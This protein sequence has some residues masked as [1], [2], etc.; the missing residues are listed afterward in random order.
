MIVFQPSADSS[1][2]VEDDVVVQTGQNQEEEEIEEEPEDQPTA[3]VDT[4]AGDP[5][6]IEDEATPESNIGK[7]NQSF[8]FL[9]SPKLFLFF[10]I[11]GNLTKCA[12]VQNMVYV[13]RLTKGSFRTHF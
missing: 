2:P 1:Q 6:P 13:L 3:S 5:E 11:E 9:S 12:Y 4:E 8:C 10:F 7:C